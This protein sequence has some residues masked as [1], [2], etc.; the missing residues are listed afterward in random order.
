MLNLIQRAVTNI[1]RFKNLLVYKKLDP[2][3]FYVSEP[4]KLIYIEN[5]KVGCS[6][7]KAAMFPGLKSQGMDIHEYLRPLARYNLKGMDKDYTVFTVVRNPLDRIVSCFTDKVKRSAED[8]GEKSIFD[9]FFYKLVFFIFS[10]KKYRG[11]NTTFEDFVYI[12][13]R[14]PD[15]ISDRHFRSQSSSLCSEDIVVLKLETLESDCDKMLEKNNIHISNVSINKSSV[16]TDW[17]FFFK[18][19]K[20]L[21]LAIKRYAKDFQNFQYEIPLSLD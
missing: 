7:I 12:I 4:N 1:V 9:L 13:S 18:D 15:W 21:N 19:E 20:T 3:E 6:T 5:A 8:K 17:R 16:N 2:I 14:V 10:G 11:E